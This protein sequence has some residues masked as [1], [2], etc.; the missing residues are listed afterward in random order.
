MGL[1]VTAD[2]DKKATAMTPTVATDMTTGSRRTSRPGD[3]GRGTSGGA[4][5]A[6]SAVGNAG[7]SC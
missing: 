4:A 6:M 1:R 5:T 7:G 3:A 2:P